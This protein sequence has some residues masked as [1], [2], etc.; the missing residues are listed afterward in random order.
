MGR[1]LEGLLEATRDAHPDVRKETDMRNDPDP[2]LRRRVRGVLA[3][4]RR[5]GRLNVG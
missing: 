4:Y 3:Q 2:R 1:D 5:T